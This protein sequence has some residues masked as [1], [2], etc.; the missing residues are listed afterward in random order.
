MDRRHGPFCNRVSLLLVRASHAGALWRDE[1]ESVQMARLPHFVGCGP[2][3]SIQFLSGSFSVIVRIYTTLFGASDI[4]L[5]C[6]GF[7]VGVFF[8]G[9]AWLHSRSVTREWPLLLPALIGLNT[10]FLTAG[11]S[12]RGY[13]I[14][15]VLVVLA[16]TLT[17]RLLLQP[18]RRLLLGVFLS[19][20]ASMQC[21]FFNGAI[22]RRL[23]WRR[24]LY[25]WHAAS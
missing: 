16:F 22:A 23:F 5:R 19:Y 20:L 3:P 1:A 24:Q 13:G 12:V 10:N 4:S 25:F 7:A 6:F 2:K 18:S 8:L 15:S 21:L 17:A 14:G 9:V 11:T